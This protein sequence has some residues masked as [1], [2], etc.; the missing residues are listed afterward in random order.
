MGIKGIDV[1]SFQGGINWD[2]VK[3]AGYN[4]AMLK[5]G[6]GD[7]LKNQDDK[8][9]SYNV[10]ECERVGLDWGA[11]LYSYAL[12][13]E[14]AQSEAQHIL[15]VLKGLNPTYP[16]ALDMEDADGYKSKNGMPSNDM[17]VNICETVLSTLEN[18][19]YYACLYAS[20]SWFENQLCSP[21]LD[22]Y[23]KWVAQWSDK[24]TYVGSYGMWQYTD[25]ESVSGIGGHVDADVAYKDYPSIMKTKGLNGF[26]SGSAT[27]TPTTPTYQTYTV[28]KGD[29]LWSIAQEL[30]GAGS[31][32]T[33][34]KALN[35]LTGDTIYPG[36]VLK[37]PR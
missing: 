23:D 6:I 21:E 17:L 20:K 35:G 2:A 24:C 5:L 12:D 11:Y 25:N 10:K 4:F 26:S 3:S 14:D 22:C 29:T 13:I 15:R 34:I 16:I 7:D 1:S 31:K 36:Q 19:G 27:A 9:F 28:Q 32:Y 33:E 30:L 37:I 18:A 8:L